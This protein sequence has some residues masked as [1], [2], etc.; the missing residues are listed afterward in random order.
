MNNCLCAYAC[1]II[2]DNLIIIS[3][4]NPVVYSYLHSISKRG[5]VTHGFHWLKKEVVFQPQLLG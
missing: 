1:L 4:E 2:M 3:I 5:Y